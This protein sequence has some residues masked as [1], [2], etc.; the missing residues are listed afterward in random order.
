[1]DPYE[2][3]VTAVLAVWSLLSALAQLGPVAP[4]LT[5]WQHRFDVFGLI[6]RYHFFAPRP[7]THDYHL[8]IRTRPHGGTFGAWRE[9][10]P[11]QPRHWWNAVWNP[12]RRHHKHLFDLGTT[13]ARTD[14][15]CADPATA[16][17]VPYLLVLHHVTTLVEPAEGAQVQF[18]IARS[19]GHRP[20]EPPE[21][22][23]LSRAHQV[24]G[25]AG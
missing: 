24:A 18:L 21:G 25:T 12:D 20:A 3:T 19:A 22:V 7:G 13:L 10:T 16:L 9:V 23:F 14:P 2:S 6:P 4:R 17:S 5:A 1:M 11:G 15:G 8:L